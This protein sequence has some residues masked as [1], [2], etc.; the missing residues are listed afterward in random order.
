M[1]PGHADLHALPSPQS[2]INDYQNLSIRSG[3]HRFPVCND[4]TTSLYSALFN[5]IA[6][7]VVEGSEVPCFYDVPPP[8]PGKAYHF[9]GIIL[10]Y[11]P[12]DGGTT[13]EFSCE[14]GLILI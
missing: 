4:G 13:Q 7:T 11:T 2:F 3:G 8:P 12:G 9:D 5:N 6:D 10:R 1:L 14:T